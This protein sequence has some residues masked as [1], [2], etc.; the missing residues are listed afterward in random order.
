M[1]APQATPDSLDDLAGEYVLGTLSAQARREVQARLTHD[2]ALRSAVTRWEE[3]L[4]PLT[5]LS[6]PVEPSASLWPRITRTLD[7]KRSQHQP[8][9]PA[10]VRA[11]GIACASGVAWRPVA[12]L[13]C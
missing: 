2:A 8:S 4:L 7:G 10:A 11:C 9:A 5:N 1:T 12:W 3:R 13:P 6:S